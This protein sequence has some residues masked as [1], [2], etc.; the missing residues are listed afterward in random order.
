ML[1]SRILVTAVVIAGSLAG[2]VH[3]QMFT[4]IG[5]L[6]GGYETSHA[7]AVSD[8]GVVV[9]SSSSPGMNSEAFRWSFRSGIVGLGALGPGSSGL[10]G[11][12]ATGISSDGR[13]VIGPS[14]AEVGSQAFRWTSGDGMMGLGD[15]PGGQRRRRY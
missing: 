6:A 2:T 10:R 8:N 14:T 11:S 4:G 13:V 7:Q 15:L 12:A 5:H 9:G 1:I 3:A